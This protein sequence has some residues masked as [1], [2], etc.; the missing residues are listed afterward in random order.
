MADEPPY[1]DNERIK[2]VSRTLF[3]LGGALFAASAVK[4]YGDRAIGFEVV[5]WFLVSGIVMWVG[6]LILALLESEK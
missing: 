3:Q 6:W 1:V 5:L 2:S 4:L